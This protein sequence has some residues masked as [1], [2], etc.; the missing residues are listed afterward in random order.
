MPFFGRN[1]RA[2]FQVGNGLRERRRDA[3]RVGNCAL[4]PPGAEE[5]RAQFPQRSKNRRKS[6]SPNGFSG[7][8]RWELRQFGVRSAEFGRMVRPY[9][10][11]HTAMPWTGQENG[12]NPKGQAH[13]AALRSG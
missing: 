10:V 9:G 4:P 8:A 12:L 2:D 6:V 1:A 5:G 3:E 13:V 11:K 7:T